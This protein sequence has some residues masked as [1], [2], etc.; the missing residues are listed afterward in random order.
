MERLRILRDGAMTFDGGW[1]RVANR[2]GPA[3]PVG[4]RFS[5]DEMPGVPSPDGK[6]L[7]R[8]LSAATP[9]GM[10][11]FYTEILVE[12][13]D[14]GKLIARFPLDKARG[15]RAELIA[16]SADSRRLAWADSATS[17]WVDP[18]DT[19]SVVTLR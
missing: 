13:L 2:G 12:E 9:G 16:W 5:D 17:N 19:L 18:Q 15:L 6:W 10:A 11:R 1:R 4:R 3:E 8:P 7:A 14:S